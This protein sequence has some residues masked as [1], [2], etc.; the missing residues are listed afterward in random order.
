MDYNDIIKYIPT[1]NKNIINPITNKRAQN[2]V[3]DFAQRHAS[4]TINPTLNYLDV[5]NLIDNGI[6]PS[7]TL[8]NTNVEARLDDNQAW[9]TK[10]F[11][12]AAQAVVSEMGLGTIVQGLQIADGISQAL[13]EPS[14]N[15][16]YSNEI[17]DYFE[18]LQDKFRKFAPV[19]YDQN[20]TLLS[21]GLTDWGWWGNNLP[22][23]MS[24]L[25][26]LIP[27]KGVIG[28]SSFILK[29][30]KLTSGT[31]KLVNTLSKV[32]G[33]ESKLYKFANNKAVIDVTN[34]AIKLG[35]SGVIMRGLENYQ[36]ARGVYNDMLPE[37]VNTIS[38]MN[39][40]QYSEFINRNRDLFKDVN[41]NDKYEVAKAIAR[42]SADKDFI[43]NWRN[44][45]SDIWQL[46]ALKNMFGAKAKI[47][48]RGSI[49]KHR[50]DRLSRRYFGMTD[51]EIEAAKKSTSTLQKV[52]DNIGDYVYGS[53]VATVAEL[54]EGAEEVVNYIAQQEGMHLGRYILGKQVD[55]NGNLIDY[56]KQ[57]S[58]YDWRLGSYFS[59]GQ[60]WDSAFWGVLGGVV[61]NAGGNY[62]NK[63]Q[64]NYQRNKARKE[65]LEELKKVG[66]SQ[67]NLPNVSWLD[68][69]ELPE[70]ERAV[71]N[72]EARNQRAQEYKAKIDAINSHRN[73]YKKDNN[74][75]DFAKE[76]DPA[77]LD[78]LRRKA[79]AEFIADMGINAIHTGTYNLD[80]EFLSS[81]T[82]R[83]KLVEMGILDENTAKEEQQSLVKEFSNIS[84]IYNKHFN[85][86]AS[87][88]SSYK[89]PIPLEYIAMAASGN[90][91]AEI[92]NNFDQETIDNLTAQY[93]QNKSTIDSTKLNS[94]FD[95]EGYLDLSAKTTM[96]TSLYRERAKAKAAVAKD[97]S[98]TNS[99][100]LDT[101]NE[102]ITKLQN[103]II[104]SENN[105]GLAGLV[106]SMHDVILHGKKENF[107]ISD[108]E[109][110][111]NALQND[112]DVTKFAKS[113]GLT[114]EKIIKENGDVDKLL[115]DSDTIHKNFIDRINFEEKA[116]NDLGEGNVNLYLNA[117]LLKQ[118]IAERKNQMI[119]TPKDFEHFA[120]QANNTLNEARINAINTSRQTIK[121]LTKKYGKGI[122]SDAIKL[123]FY[124]KDYDN[125][126][127]SFEESDKKSLTDALKILNFAYKPNT[128]LISIIERDINSAEQEKIRSDKSNESKSNNSEIVENTSKEE[129]VNNTSSEEEEQHRA[130][131]NG[132]QSNV[133]QNIIINTDEKTPISTYGIITPNADGTFEFDSDD[134]S[135]HANKDLYDVEDGVSVIDSNYKVAR[136]LILVQNEQ[137]NY[138]LASN[139]KGLLVK[140]STPTEEETT[141]ETEPANPESV[142]NNGV[143][144][145]LPRREAETPVPLPQTTSSST[146]VG[147]TD[148]SAPAATNSNYVEPLMTEEELDNMLS[149]AFINGVAKLQ[150]TGLTF[151]EA[152]D[153]AKE[154]VMTSPHKGITDEAFEQAVD[155]K[156]ALI[157]K[158]AEIL[159]RRK[160]KEDPI[161][162]SAA[163]VVT[164]TM[165]VEYENDPTINK[166]YD[167][168]IGTFIKEYAKLKLIPTVNGK[169]IINIR[170]LMNFIN[171]SFGTTT[172]TRL[173][174]QVWNSLRTYFEVHSNNYIIEDKENLNK[175]DIDDVFHVQSIT[176][177]LD[178]GDLS[179]RI[180]IIDGSL[181]A[182]SLGSNYV[183]HRNDIMANM[184][185]GD[186]LYL[187]YNAARSRKWFD[188][189]TDDGTLVGTM[190]VPV[191]VGNG[192]QVYEDGWRNNM[193][194]TTNGAE[195]D[196][197]TFVKNLFCLD[198]PYTTSDGKQIDFRDLLNIVANARINGVKNYVDAFKNNPIIQDIVNQSIDAR[199][200]NH[201]GFVYVTGDTVN[202]SR[203]L[204]GLI[205]MY[206]YVELNTT[207]STLGGN[208]NAHRANIDSYFNML[209]NAYNALSNLPSSEIKEVE[210]GYIND[211]QIHFNTTKWN[212][213]AYS[214]YTSSD[215]AFRDDAELGLSIVPPYSDSLIVSNHEPIKAKG[216]T[217]GSTFVTLY[218]RNAQPSYV[219]AVGLTSSYKNPDDAKNPVVNGISSAI[220]ARWTNLLD[221][222]FNANGTAELDK[223]YKELLNFIT[224][225][226]QCDETHCNQLHTPCSSAIPIFRAS[227][228][229]F[230]LNDIDTQGNR[231]DGF[232]LSYN[233]NGK[234]MSI[235][236]YRR[237]TNGSIAY[238]IVNGDDIKT[239]KDGKKTLPPIVFNNNKHKINIHGEDVKLVY[240]FRNMMRDLA[241]INISSTGIYMDNGVS[242]PR[243]GFIRK[244][245]GKVKL[246]IP[247]KRN[248]INATYELSADS[249]SD[250]IIKNGLVRVNTSITA[251]GTNYDTRGSNQKANQNLY[252]SVPK[253]SIVGY[254]EASDV[255]TK[256]PPVE[257]SDVSKSKSE[258][259]ISIIANNNDNIKDLVD[260]LL[261]HNAEFERA[262][263]DGYIYDLFP[264]KLSYDSK[265]NDNK[266]NG[267]VAVAKND[268]TNQY[269]RS[270]KEVV[271]FG[272]NEVVVGSI[273]AE[274]V[275]KHPNVAAR[276]LIH[277]RIHQLLNP[278]SQYKMNGLTAERKANLIKELSSIYNDFRA[279]LDTFDENNYDTYKHIFKD[280]EFGK[281]AIHNVKEMFTSRES[282]QSKERLYEEFLAESLT[283]Q[284]VYEIC[285]SYD[286]GK[287]QS[288]VAKGNLITRI[289]DFIRKIFGWSKLNNNSI[290]ARELS[291][292]RKAFASNETITTTL[293]ETKTKVKDD[294]ISVETPPAGKKKKKKGGAHQDINFNNDNGFDGLFSISVETIVE[295]NDNTVM[296]PAM[297]EHGLSANEKSKFAQ[298]L[299]AGLINLSCR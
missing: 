29:G 266:G 119:T 90:T 234:T 141:P 46:Y 16:D 64:Y 246:E 97:N 191:N 88:T 152:I 218:G 199:K 252:I 205:K 288:R 278:N 274:Q 290:M 255:S 244:V 233:L 113:I 221:N 215:K 231:N 239:D 245:D 285:N 110:G 155:E 259:V 70:V 173:A 39:P 33:T 181:K 195:S 62:I 271:D 7:V 19:H 241:S 187:Q 281:R 146:G 86:I 11:N 135:A 163:S 158:R 185:V 93:E 267:D 262:R 190:T 124:S 102:R 87:I 171:N 176:P 18:D 22:S 269:L 294:T 51:K 53:R 25:T 154:L 253:A 250:M 289:A 41:V 116:K 166:I 147:Q 133:L 184:Q 161:S 150:T 47:T 186:K 167:K 94:T 61:F 217:T 263:R 127:S 165:F 114:D 200:N 240:A 196:F 66:I 37:A 188:V 67:E 52:K 211:G 247:Y 69:A 293:T 34:D 126:T 275:E 229:N 74:G 236:I 230:V 128:G 193:I 125:I 68:M 106:V 80:K 175:D 58:S 258:Q 95:Y 117:A 157:R 85:N 13:F 299:D 91:R 28:L 226:V 120:N 78:Q 207:E 197:K 265:L 283:R 38:R 109:S 122:V 223:A 132:S 220:I 249:Y 43:Y 183:A 143:E 145:T 71:S 222:F 153:K 261:P 160:A 65:R 251:N 144:E 237:T 105:L 296:S 198:N 219:R 83:K 14:N 151:D 30:L 81:E 254:K 256:T 272:D 214:T 209:Y 96:L 79:R 138:E 24:S 1:P 129:G 210:V 27:T 49:A 248:D 92:E 204:N 235:S 123:D 3:A 118:R 164:T 208:I 270:N 89:A 121:N 9:Y 177:K 44:V 140:A 273:W 212:D 194:L 111:Y 169:T 50:A 279:Y 21:G 12:G 295:T 213:E 170:D 98:L 242:N 15:R 136:K 112:K 137:G 282:K 225:A 8:D 264:H 82:V 284:D 134:V 26:M 56:D 23:I 139:G 101:I 5:D 297:A 203:L 227:A 10:I 148:A 172:D 149:R 243:A 206:D 42:T 115:N 130:Q 182:N 179:L 268:K 4:A 287:S 63:V 60:L 107:D 103:D 291:V 54:G 280:K 55:M 277:E 131:G 104:A 201:Y 59:D 72:I 298:M 286:Y 228:G 216:F 100:V 142:E 156:I 202:Y 20:K 178:E 17:I 257:E 57:H 75:K 168:V 180:N 260:T 162:N 292:V 232:R 276:V 35:A 31:R 192:L 32:A 224:S 36:E 189:R 2:N 6:A 73:P 159:G 84:K 45:I 77:I 108:I 174:G 48:E 238:R 99:I 76:E 40:Q